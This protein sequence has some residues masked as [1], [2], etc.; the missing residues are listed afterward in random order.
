MP[1]SGSFLTVLP[2]GLTHFLVTPAKANV[3]SLL[4]QVEGCCS[5]RWRRGWPPRHLHLH[6]INIDFNFIELNN[7][8]VGVNFIEG[9][10]MNA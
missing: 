3:P 7:L 2:A 10:G 4:D 5:A 8:E 6:K 1:G 9:R